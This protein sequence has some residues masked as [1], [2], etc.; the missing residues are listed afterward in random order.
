MLT[1]YSDATRDR[2]ITED[3]MLE[4]FTASLVGGRIIVSPSLEG[5]LSPSMPPQL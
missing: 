3:L 5:L 2:D 1:L 4:E